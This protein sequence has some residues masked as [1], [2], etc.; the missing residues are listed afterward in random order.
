[1]RSSST[2]YLFTNCIQLKHHN[3]KLDLHVQSQI[4]NSVVQIN[5]WT[6]AVLSLDAFE[7]LQETG[8]KFPTISFIHFS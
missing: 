1:M 3:F 6:S 2:I 7:E 8:V 5:L 4:H